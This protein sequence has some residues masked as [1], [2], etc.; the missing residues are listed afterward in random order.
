LDWGSPVWRP[1]LDVLMRRH[2][3]VRYDCR[4]CG[5]SDREQV[6]FS[7]EKFVEDLEA[8]AD[9]GGL[10]RFVLFGT[11]AGAAIGAAYAVR[12]PERVSH[13]VLYA[14]YSRNKLGG[15]PTPQEVDEAQARIKIM[16]LGWPDDTP[17][18]GRFYPYLHMPDASVE[19]RRAFTELVRRTT[20]VANAVGLLQV[21]YR[22]DV[23]EIVP[24]IRCPTL[25]LHARGDS[26]IWFEQGRS[27][28][29]LIPGA[30][31]VP[32]ESRNHV[33]QDTEPAWRQFVEALD[34]LLPA[35]PL[36][37]AGSGALV[38]DELTSRENQVLELVAQG[39]DNATIGDRLHISERTARNH[40]S[41]ILAK[42]GINTRAQAIVRAREAGFG[43]Q[44]TL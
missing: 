34:E 32:L 26:V 39:L 23:R 30:R 18:Y 6:E 2:T 25:V 19:Q 33:L 4:G 7:F 17:A 38:L 41:A 9:A 14:G 29:G 24:K 22:I 37:P 43:Q 15:S 13:L 11:T 16:Q 44:K 42:L 12:H 8:V 36:G 21:F 35:T 1:W 3:L 10:E 20:T 31:F 28:A 5:L 40:V 27:V